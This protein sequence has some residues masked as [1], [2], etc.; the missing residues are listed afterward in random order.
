[1]CISV[2]QQAIRRVWIWIIGI[3]ILSISFEFE[4]NPKITRAFLPF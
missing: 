1:M 3:Q 4:L 2:S